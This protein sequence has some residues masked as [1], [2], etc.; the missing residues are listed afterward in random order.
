M[1]NS[2][3]ETPEAGRPPAFRT[4]VEWFGF[5][6]DFADGE[7]VE[8][9]FQREGDSYIDIHTAVQGPVNPET[10]YFTVERECVVRIAMRD[11][12]DLAL[13]GFGQNVLD[14]LVF[15][16]SGDGWAIRL[17]ACVGMEGRIVCD[18][19]DFTIIPGKPARRFRGEFL[20]TA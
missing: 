8:A 10:G 7:I 12:S 20:G 14:E 1:K 19:V 3:D 15:E 18:S 9:F 11:V 17:R 16:R 6:P 13:S 4:L 2:P 5:W